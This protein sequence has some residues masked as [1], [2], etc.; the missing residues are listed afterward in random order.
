MFTVV[1]LTNFKHISI[2]NISITNISRVKAQ[3]LKV[4]GAI[5][6]RFFILIKNSP[7]AHPYPS[8]TG[9]NGSQ[10]LPHH[11]TILKPQPTINYDRFEPYGQK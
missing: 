5:K 2:T 1:P 11:Q 3:G 9:N 10:N 4:N 8:A 6:S 7:N